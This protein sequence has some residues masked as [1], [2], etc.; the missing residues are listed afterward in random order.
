MVTCTHGSASL[1]QT[2]EMFVRTESGRSSMKLS[3][4]S[5][6]RTSAFRP[7][8]A[9]SSSRSSWYMKV[10]TSSLCP[11]RRCC[12]KWRSTID[13]AIQLLLL[14]TRRRLPPETGPI[15]GADFLI[16]YNMMIDFCNRRLI[17][18]SGY[19]DLLISHRSYDQC[20]ILLK[21]DTTVRGEHRTITTGVVVNPSGDDVLAAGPCL[22]E[23]SS[24]FSDRTGVLLARALVETSSGEIPVQQ[25]AH[26]GPVRLH[27]GTVVGHVS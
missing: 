4:S 19:V 17:W 1:K 24:D 13:R 23:P 7:G 10:S 12:N 27:K 15:V 8:Q 20:R 11:K 14:E 5:R 21:E 9:R 18:S 3:S 26:G 6:L 16:S 2:T 25:M 22:F